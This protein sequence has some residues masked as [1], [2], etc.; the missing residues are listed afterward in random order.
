M[1]NNDNNNLLLICST[2]PRLIGLPEAFGPIL[3]KSVFEFVLLPGVFNRSIIREQ[4]SAYQP[5]DLCIH[6][7]QSVFDFAGSVV[8][9]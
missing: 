8:L 3:Q 9:K 2:L 5:P 1:N 7:N 6:I 4:C